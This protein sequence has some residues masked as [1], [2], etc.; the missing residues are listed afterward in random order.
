[1]QAKDCKSSLTIIFL[2]TLI[3]ILAGG[4][5]FPT[6]LSSASPLS[7]IKP[8][9]EASDAQSLFPL[10]L[11][12][13]N[14]IIQEISSF[15]SRMTG[16]PG[17]YR[18][19]DY[20]YDYLQNELKIM[21]VVYK[22]KV[23]VPYDEET[24]IQVLEPFSTRIDAYAL[25]PN[26]V[27]P[28]PTPPEGV[29]GNLVYVKDGS[30][31]NFDGKVI[32]GSIV[33]MDFNS[34]DNWIKAANLGAQA[35]VF[36]EP[37]STLY[38]EC[39]VKFLDTPI[40]FPR[41]YVKKADW[42]LLKDA[43]KIKLV[44]RVYWKEIEA[45]NL[46]A[47]INGTG[48]SD[49][50]MLSTHFDSWSV[51]P[52]LAS[53]K[54]ELLPLALLLDYAHYL[55]NNPPYYTVWLVFYSGHWQALK[56]PREFVEDVFFSEEVMS[57]RIT[58]RGNINFDLIAS[59]CDGLQILQSS[60]YS[61]YGGNSIH[62]AGMGVRLRWFVSKITEDILLRDEVARFGRER[63]RAN[64][65]LN[66][67]SMQVAPGASGGYNVNPIGTEPYPYMLDSEPVSISGIAAFSITAR[68]SN[69]LYVGS[70]I[71]DEKYADLNVLDPYLQ[72]ALYITDDLLKTEWSGVERVKPERYL[73]VQSRGFPGYA[74]LY[75]RVVTYNFSKGWYDGVPNAI[76]EL[77]LNTQ[78][79]PS[80]YKLNRI[81]MKTDEQGYFTVHGVP[82][83]GAAAGG[84]VV[85]P[86][87]RWI[88]QAWVFDDKG[89]ILMA[90]D[91]GQFGMS[92]FPQEVIILHE[93]ENIT[94]V[95]AN[96]VSV[97]I[98]DFEVPTEFL[99]PSIRDPR[100]GTFE[101][102]RFSRADVMPLEFYSK[103]IPISYGS[104]CNGWEPVSI[105]WIQ[106][107]VRF[108]ILGTA[109]LF[110]NSSAENT[111]G[112]G[113]YVNYGDKIRIGFSALQI[114]RDLYYVSY[115]RYAK[116][117][118]ES[119]GSPSADET[120][121]K[122][123]EYLEKAEKFLSDKKYSEA[124]NC[125]LMARAYAAKAY[126][127]E[128]MPLINDSARS[129]L[130]IF[131]IIILGAFFLEKVLIHAQGNKR[132]IAIVAFGGF[133]LGLF[134]MVH[135]VFGLMS[136]ISLG[137]MGSLILVVLLITVIILLS[138][139][140]EVRSGIEKRV[141]GVHRA[142]ISRLDTAMISFSLGSEHMR[143]RPLRAIL[144]LLTM[145][146]MIIAITSFTS[147][148]PSRLSRDVVWPTTYRPSL[149][150]ILIKQGRG[151]PPGMLS[152]E[153]LSVA[154]MMAGDE[155]YV[156][157]RVW[158]YANLDRVLAAALFRVYSASNYTTVNALMG[159]TQ[160]DFN[161]IF[162]KIKGNITLGSRIL[163][164]DSAIISRKLAD[165]LDVEVGDTIR[166]AGVNFT[167]M[168]IVES[169][170]LIDY[171]IEA[172]GWNMFPGNPIYFSTISRD[173]TQQAPGAIPQN[174]GISTTILIPYE[175]ALRLGGYIATIALVPKQPT[176]Y[177]N[178]LKLARELAYATDL[179][180]YISYEGT[181]RRMST[182]SSV[183]LG[184]WEIIWIILIIG[185][186]NIFTTVL[187]S[188]KE[189]AREVYIFSVVGLSPM[190]VTVFFMTEV[191]VY[192][193]IST[194]IGYVSGYFATRLFMIL[195]ILPST[196]VFNFASLFTILGTLI[197]IASA[198]AAS[199][200]PSYIASRVVTP[201]LER[202]WK[203][204]T[205]PK[206][207]EWEI[208]LL[209]SIPTLEES[210]G[211]MAYLHEY[212]SGGGAVKEGIH[213][214]KDLYP[215][216][217][218]NLSLSLTVSLSPFEV[219][220]L[221]AVTVSAKFNEAIKRYEAILHLKRLSGP[222]NVWETS[223]Y[224]FV[225]DLR[226]QLLMWGSFSASEKTKYISR[227]AG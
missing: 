202:R 165:T 227:A 22:Y 155:Y 173:Q 185:A 105:A 65:S 46:V 21:P 152:E 68:S 191:L 116:L 184:G 113:L 187:G 73:L 104:Y 145:I 48:S 117:A 136:N 81:V 62:G 82:I 97:E 99:T 39:E 37:E 86:F 115:G 179:S 219:G 201:S 43:S 51:V 161:L 93:Y 42:E 120:L 47:V 20:L 206:E 25:Y 171:I 12:R 90:T 33:A 75:G 63:L 138:L 50:V 214:V 72:L 213:M 89:T 193:V 108:A 159:I 156:L 10:N 163:G 180:I 144:V 67:V 176:S 54:T 205:K 149:N 129:L 139:S 23:L 131:V 112:Y 13:M 216:D 122:A 183:L 36:I 44:S 151:V 132:L 124:Y 110:T 204:K 133:F 114:A 118:R 154:S 211:V 40:C 147:L 16:Y 2:I 226:K 224:R 41:V 186:L 158:L 29:V 143:R 111:E 11:Q 203:F 102:W 137:M 192:A 135:P 217:Y 134:A 121:N 127:M 106:P 182:Y 45:V 60:Y 4:Q 32:E 109:V 221:Q 98:F 130:Y 34:R 215:P 64:N 167:V 100:A 220:V 195:G 210:R 8:S 123:K 126:S 71:S 218:E 107:N 24:Y 17:Y 148:T 35:V 58:I 169:P 27:N 59:D 84:N 141:L 77:K 209:I 18:T 56:G 87:S 70:P 76:V 80:T 146:T 196:H 172:D 197:V 190:G 199:S 3:I 95:V 212:Y 198:L 66:L 79:G 103:S 38:P 222:R 49:V 74:T 157:P 28:S 19:L 9:T 140:E 55:K 26:G 208:P 160:E 6:V 188:L 83:S 5:Y 101:R 200:Y 119:V 92:R 162:E 128:V 52:G 175:K 53:S 85:I 88:A 91:M 164:E 150:E 96:V 57:G 207:D 15:G 142:E 168:G 61:T 170:D 181:S 14:S 1:M 31:K 174:L 177:E 30:L 94:V 223:N 166:V 78:W 189:R 7:T 153:V 125:A 178:M 225:N 69:R 194:L